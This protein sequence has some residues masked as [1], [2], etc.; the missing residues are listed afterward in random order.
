MSYRQSIGANRQTGAVLVTAMLLLLVMTIIGI[1]ATSTT[2]MEER[3]ASNVRQSEIAHQAA[4]VALRNAEDMFV[5]G[6]GSGPTPLTLTNIGTFFDG[7][8][9]G[10]YARVP[11]NSLV[12]ITLDPVTSTFDVSD[13]S[14]WTAA[15]SLQGDAV[16]TTATNPPPAPRF[17]I[18]YVGSASNPPLDPNETNTT[19]KFAFRITAIGWGQ[20][21]SAG[22]RVSRIV[23]STYRKKL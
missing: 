18:E 15:N 8:M 9:P 17:V 12:K 6:F 20:E 21:T 2:V 22:N 11:G 7:T 10:L 1:S 4:E 16:L 3:M 5:T 13:P 19:T 23:S 14:Q